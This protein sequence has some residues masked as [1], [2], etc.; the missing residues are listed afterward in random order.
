MQLKRLVVA[1]SL[2]TLAQTASAASPDWR[3]DSGYLYLKDR[4]DRPQDGYCLDVAGSGEWV[5]FNMPLN[6]H[7]CKRP[8]FYA[9]EAVTF[10]SPGEI[11]FPAYDGCVTAVGIQGRSLPGA[12]LMLKPCAAEVD[13]AKLPYVR[14]ELQHFSHREDGRIELT[15]SG[16]C[17]QVGP[18]SDTTFSTEHR[19]R[20]LSMAPC[21]KAPKSLSVWQAFA[22]EAAS[23]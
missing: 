3:D 13:T 7:N 19:W 1:A 18:T 9:D 5:D 17:I 14:E 21:D 22:P 20:S 2:I 16:L 4:L 12:A 23:N 11:R 15:G 10:N 6:G 8:G